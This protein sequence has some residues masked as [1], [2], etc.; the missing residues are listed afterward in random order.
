MNVLF[1]LWIK[2]KLSNFKRISNLLCWLSWSKQLFPKLQQRPEKQWRS[3]LG[4]MCLY[5]EWRV[6]EHF[7]WSTDDMKQH[8]SHGC[9]GQSRDQQLYLGFHKQERGRGQIVKKAGWMWGVHY[10]SPETLEILSKW[11]ITD[12]FIKHSLLTWR[13]RMKMESNS[14]IN[15]SVCAAKEQ[16]WTRQ[17]NNRRTSVINSR[18]S[19]VFWWAEKVEYFWCCQ[20]NNNKKKTFL[21]TFHNNL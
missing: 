9:R 21:F 4:N 20:E 10:Y 17:L 15:L 19:C 11:Q 14:Y 12:G 5:S 6:W 2:W 18:I 7:H 1:S 8:L 16:K 13:P 3:D